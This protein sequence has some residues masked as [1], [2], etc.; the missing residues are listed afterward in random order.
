MYASRIYLVL[1]LSA[2]ALL[3]ACAGMDAQE[4]KDTDWAYLGQLDAM[5]GKQDITTRA[6][7]HFRACKDNGVQMDVRAYQQGWM[8]GL[9]GFCT[10]ESGKAFAEAGRK[11][12]YG[13]CPA[14][15]EPAFLQGYGPVR[16]R[17]DM[18]E[19]M[20]QLE[21]RIDTKKKELREARSAKNSASHIAY[22]EK[23]LRDLNVEMLQ[24]RFK[25]AQMQPK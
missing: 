3:S 24:L 19:E 8:Q 1:T 12:Q 7:R 6:K 10:A 16:E 14:Q 21:R 11:Y 25:F 2:A 23:D 5:D 9:R 4:C 22:V 17:L 15:V 18:Q 13:Y 20:A